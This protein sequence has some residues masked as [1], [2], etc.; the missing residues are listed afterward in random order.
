MPSSLTNALISFQLLYHF[1]HSII[2]QQDPDFSCA[3]EDKLGNMGDGHKWICD[4]W[5]I[6]KQES[7]LVYSIGSNGL[8]DFEQA[9]QDVVG[10]CEIHIFDFDNYSHKLPKGLNVTL[11]RWGL[12]PVHDVNIPVTQSS[13]MV[14]RSTFWRSKPQLDWKTL[15]EI[16][17]LLGHGG[18]VIDIF[19][20]DCEGC[21]WYTFPDWFN[22]SAEIR[23]IAVEVHEAPNHVNDFFSHI[24]SQNYVM[25]H[26]EPNI[27]WSNGNCIEFSFLKLN[28]SFFEAPAVL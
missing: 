6:A 16:V 23:Q 25:F 18:R 3:A 17:E 7:C 27:Q 15:P 8:F 28:G 24:H 22:T 4:P 2:Y 13:R 11:H 20:I 10:N 26:K 5:R 9:I 21:E 1:L 14:A 12:K 19:K